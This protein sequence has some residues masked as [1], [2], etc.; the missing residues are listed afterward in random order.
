MQMNRLDRAMTVTCATLLGILSLVLIGVGLVLVTFGL[1]ADIGSRFA[2]IAYA[3]AF[4]VV[5]GL[6]GVSGE[7]LKRKR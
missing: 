7:R 3:M 1:V 5:G 6:T 2:I 4:F